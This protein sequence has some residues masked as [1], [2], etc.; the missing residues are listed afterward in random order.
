MVKQKKKKVDPAARKR[1]QDRLSTQKQANKFVDEESARVQQG[2]RAGMSDR[3]LNKAGPIKKP[4]RS[5]GR[6][7][8][9][10]GRPPLYGPTEQKAYM[11]KPYYATT[12]KKVTVKGKKR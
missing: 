12:M 7:M 9:V 2:N 8:P 5:D 11:A 10:P 1:K 6:P 3:E 4:K